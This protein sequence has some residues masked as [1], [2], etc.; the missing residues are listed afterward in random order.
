M[1]IPST[2]TTKPTSK[3]STTANLGSAIAL[4]LTL[5]LGL[6]LGLTACQ[7]QQSTAEQATIEYS[8]INGETM[9][10]SYHISFE[11]PKG[12]DS[13]AIQAE[14][15]KK[16]VAF[17]NELSTWQ[18]DSTISQFN[19]APANEPIGIQADFLQVFKDSK[20]VY[21]QSSGAFDPTVKPIL[22]LWG[23]GT[24]M[25]VDRL[26]NPPSKA[27]T[28]KAKALIDF[29][30]ITL[31]GGLATKE[32]AGYLVKSKDG[33]ALDFSAIAKGYGVD[34]IANVL[35]SEYQINNYMVE[36]GGE[37]AT[38]GVNNKGKGWQIAIDAPVLHSGVTNRQ[39]IATIR[40][41][42]SK[43]KTGSMHLA[44]SGN[45]RNSI[46]FDGVRY[47]HTIDPHT[48]KPVVGGASSVTVAHSS[49]ALADAWATALTA[50]P[51]MNALKYANEHGLA[52]MFIIPKEGV[53]P[54]GTTKN[55][56]TEVNSNKESHSL[57]D[58]QVIETNAMKQLRAGT[59]PDITKKVDK[60][61]LSIIPEDDIDSN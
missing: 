52:V 53:N 43:D 27:E 34:V 39:L 25:R 8:K 29:D 57:A 15:D 56:T 60:Q 31:D 2:F 42:V 28:A 12:A 9:G 5:S 1:R 17:N 23:F 55:G 44:T 26:Q 49:V 40:Q 61:T 7:P 3:L 16:L 58:W 36:I 50:M 30:S 20:A 45:Y 47:S 46:V 41:P 11:L 19:Q 35:Q 24:E 18:K 10:T 6:S 4:S 14:I 21:R 13:K 33:V 37:V 22:E 54:Q 38:S 59:M 51:Y 32:K 48:A